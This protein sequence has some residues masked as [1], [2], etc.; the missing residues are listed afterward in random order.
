MVKETH[1]AHYT[2]NLHGCYSDSGDGVGGIRLSQAGQGGEYM[3][4][5]PGDMVTII[6]PLIVD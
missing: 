3:I 1:T 4:T 5:D 6:S 2:C